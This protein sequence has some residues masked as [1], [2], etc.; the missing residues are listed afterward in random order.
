M[1]GR[2]TGYAFRYPYTVIVPPVRVPEPGMMLKLVK[3]V[4]LELMPLLVPQSDVRTQP[5]L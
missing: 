5:A 1:F 4:A 2:V 3:L